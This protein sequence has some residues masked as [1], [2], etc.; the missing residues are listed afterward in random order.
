MILYNRFSLSSP[1]YDATT[2][3]FKSV[4]KK[5]FSGYYSSP[6]YFLGI[7]FS[8]HK[9]RSGGTQSHQSY[10]HAPLSRLRGLPFSYRNHAKKIFSSSY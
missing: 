9:N 8:L 5:I 3:S 10:Y 6:N 2:G 1:T 7:R 4:A